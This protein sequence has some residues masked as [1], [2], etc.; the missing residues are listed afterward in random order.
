MH[1]RFVNCWLLILFFGLQ[2]NI[3]YLFSCSNCF[4]FDTRKLLNWL[5]CLLESSIHTDFVCYKHFTFWPYKMFQAYSVSLLSSPR[6]HH[7]SKE[8]QFLLL[9]NSVRNQDMCT[10]CA[11]SYWDLIALPSQ[12]TKEGNICVHAK[13]CI[14]THL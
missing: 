10:R 6:V 2:S 5:L 4:S 7:V 1:G 13:P 9:G 11:Y 8:P 12:L 14:C 3:T